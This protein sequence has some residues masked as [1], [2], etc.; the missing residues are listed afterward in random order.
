MRTKWSVI[1]VDENNT[2][3]TGEYHPDYG[4]Y[5]GRPFLIKN[6]ASGRVMD[7]TSDNN[8]VI[9]T[10]MSARAQTK[11]AWVFDGKTE[12]IKSQ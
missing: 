3:I 7:M 6:K 5:V 1:Y 8:I 12:T 2:F 11:Q 9:K 4:F 10:S